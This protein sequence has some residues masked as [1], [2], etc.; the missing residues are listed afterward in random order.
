LEQNSLEDPSNRQCNEEADGHVVSK[1]PAHKET[2]DDDNDVPNERTPE[3]CAQRELD[4]ANE[5]AQQ[6]QQ[7]G[8]NRDS[9]SSVK[10]VHRV[11]PLEIRCERFQFCHC[12]SR[13]LYAEL[14]TPS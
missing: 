1:R 6:K 13:L 3:G 14:Q 12:L 11:S 2:E 5:S 7:T 10:N 8:T 9:N 4:T